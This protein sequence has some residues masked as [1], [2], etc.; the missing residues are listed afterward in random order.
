MGSFIDHP[1]KKIIRELWCKPIIKHIHDKLENGLAYLG[2]PGLEAI[3]LLT[4]IE[5]IKYVVAI[6][7]GHYT[8]GNYDLA[9]AKE[10][11]K[12]LNGILN[13]LD[14]KGTISGYSLYLG[15]IEE[16]VLKGI[17]KNGEKFTQKDT[18]NIYNLDF[19]NSLT[20]PLKIVDLKGGVSKYYKNEVIRRLLEYE[21]DIE[22]PELNKRFIMFI[23]IHSKFWEEEAEIY[24]KSQND[25][26]FE[27]YKD[28]IKN[29]SEP[30]RIIRLLRYYFLDIL[31]QHFTASSFTPYFFPTIFYNGVGDN[32][33]MCFTVAGQYIKQASAIAPF[34]Q[35]IDILNHQ[36]FL[37][38]GNNKLDF[39]ISS[40]IEKNPISDPIKQI[41]DSLIFGHR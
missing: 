36:K 34:N 6:D 35:N 9:I 37:Y 19:C 20:A 17:D 41:E 24:F 29:L 23:T 4:W 14:R 12:K 5:Y 25:R 22:K 11:I 40:I 33:L 32:Q 16:V 18:V 39:I 8:T 3:D 28:Y 31:R 38:P 2:L 1:N 15:F 10:K 13:N 21:R 26:A 30:E 7:C 27:A